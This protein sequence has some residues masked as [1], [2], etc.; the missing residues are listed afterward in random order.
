MNLSFNIENTCDCSIVITDTT[1]LDNNGY[2]QVSNKQEFSPTQFRFAE[3]QCF[4][5]IVYMPF[6]KDSVIFKD[7]KMLKDRQTKIENIPD[8]WYKLE[9]IILP[10]KSYLDKAKSLWETNYYC[11]DNNNICLYNKETK[12]TE[13]IG[14]IDNLF[15]ILHNVGKDSVEKNAFVFGYKT[16]FFSLCRLE[17]CYINKVNEVFSSLCGNNI[18][19]TQNKKKSNNIYLRDLLKA[20]LDVIS[21]LIKCNRFEEA[22][23]ILS[24]IF[25]CNGICNNREI[26][27]MSSGDCGCNPN[28]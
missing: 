16:D 14:T 20:A 28:A 3:S 19:I 4:V 26:G 13:P 7:V 6:S 24:Q 10:T 12:T 18:C 5:R 1:P 21:Y 8:G 15:T 27:N 23:R 11:Y 17:K 22:N 9:A 25:K 2:L